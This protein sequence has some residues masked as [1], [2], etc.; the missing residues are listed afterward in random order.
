MARL[1]APAAATPRAKRVTREH[2]IVYGM[3]CR[4]RSCIR[5]TARDKGRK[6]P[7]AELVAMLD[8]DGIRHMTIR[9][10]RT[11]IPRSTD[12]R[13]QLFGLIE[14]L[15]VEYSVPQCLYQACI[16]GEA[17]FDFAHGLY[18]EWLVTIAQGG[19]FRR[20]AKPYLNSREAHLFMEAPPGNRVHENVWWAKLKTAGLANDAVKELIDRIY[21]FH[22]FDDPDGRLLETVRFFGR[23]HSQME[24][25]TFQE[26]RDCLAWK[27]RNE[28][29]FRMKGRTLSSMTRLTQDW[30]VEMQQAKFRSLI[31]WPGLQIRDWQH[32]AGDIL[33]KVSELTNN[34]ELLNEGRQ[35]RHCV[36]AYV[37]LCQSGKCAIFSMRRY[38]VSPIRTGADPPG[39]SE[40]PAELSR[41]TIEVN[42]CRTV[43]QARGHLNRAPSDEERKYLRIWAIEKGMQMS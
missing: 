11:Y 16:P 15:F 26:I 31:E 43:V 29:G 7:A 42:E 5:R 2:Q 13:K 39:E 3:N 37:P 4:G 30:H 23:F 24:K 40:K 6:R 12:L 38:A 28:P 34:V 41:I 32:A 10:L 22:F 1:L 35:Q 8:L 9:P 20:V 33:W 25:T 14:H 17:P 27:L 36:F 18:R 21:T 19:S